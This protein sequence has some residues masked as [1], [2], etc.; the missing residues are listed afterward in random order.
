MSRKALARHAALATRKV[1]QGT[2]L[3]LAA[4]IGAW[5]QSLVSRPDQRL[6]WQDI[7]IG[8]GLAALWLLQHPA[9]E[10]ALRHWAKGE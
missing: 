2:R 5:V 6:D 10:W 1:Q 7:G 8:L 9:S 3:A 4:L